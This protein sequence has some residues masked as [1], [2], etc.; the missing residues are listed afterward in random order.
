MIGAK[1]Q[2]LGLL[3]KFVV[4]VAIVLIA[5]GVFWHGAAENVVERMWANLIARPSGPMS[6][7]FVLQPSMAAIFAI[8]DGLRDARSG[9]SPFLW[10]ILREPQKRIERLDEGLNATARIILIG[11]AMDVIYQRI[12]FATFYPVEALIIALLLA[13]LPYVLIRGPVARIARRWRGGAPDTPNATG[14]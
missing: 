1:P 12:E 14:G 5:A 7:R 3:S 9:R 8:H 6:F 11:L 2:H 4:A 10:T 13:F